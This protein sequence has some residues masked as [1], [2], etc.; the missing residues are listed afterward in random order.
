VEEEKTKKELEDLSK[1]LLT[2]QMNGKPEDEDDKS[3]DKS[4]DKW[5][6]FFG[7]VEELFD[8]KNFNHLKSSWEHKVA[9][10]DPARTEKRLF[11]YIL[12]KEDKLRLVFAITVFITSF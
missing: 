12:E 2:L 7:T 11:L 6:L 9:L 1:V 8:W 3:D 4:D 5:T 10:H